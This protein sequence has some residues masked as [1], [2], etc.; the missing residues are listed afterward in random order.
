MRFNSM[1]ISVHYLMGFK[2]TVPRDSRLQV[3]LMNQF[4]L[5]KYLEKPQFCDFLIF[6]D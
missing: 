4:T 1:H 3:F 6:E 2:G 5:Q